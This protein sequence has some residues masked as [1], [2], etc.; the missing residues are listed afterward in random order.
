MVDACI[1]SLT[2]ASRTLASQQTLA[3]GQLFLIKNLLQLRETISIFDSKLTRSVRNIKLS[4]VLQ[5][6]LGVL[7]NPLDFS[8]YGN[9]ATP[10]NATEQSNV[11]EV[12]DEKLKDACEG[13]ITGTSTNVT[14]P[15][16]VFINEASLKS[17][18]TMFEEFATKGI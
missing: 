9:L 18:S 8:S 3:D 10:F 6:F 17:R 16:T 5:A 4:E 1:V 12:L 15:L 14:G 2:G 13:F 11:R 7:D